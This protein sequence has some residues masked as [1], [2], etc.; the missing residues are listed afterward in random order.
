MKARNP[1][2]APHVESRRGGP[3]KQPLSRDAIVTEALRQLTADGLKGMSLRKV[4]VALET[5]PASLYAAMPVAHGMGGIYSAGV[6]SH[7]ASS[8]TVAVPWP[9]GLDT[10]EVNVSLS[11]S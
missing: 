2:E 9:A 6:Y 7:L 3:A 8:S 11:T 1:F 10:V 5:G 4:A